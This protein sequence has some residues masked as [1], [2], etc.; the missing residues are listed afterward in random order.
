MYR[1]GGRLPVFLQYYLKSYCAEDGGSGDFL[2][3]G[4]L[5]HPEQ[6]S[7]DQGL[8]EDFGILYSQ[9]LIAKCVCTLCVMILIHS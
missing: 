6:Y 1:E 9:F 7:W 8:L 4:V 3:P 5:N 2:S